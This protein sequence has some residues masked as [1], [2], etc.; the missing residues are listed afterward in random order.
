M[1][2]KEL[3]KNKPDRAI[4]LQGFYL[5]KKLGPSKD[6]REEGAKSKAGGRKR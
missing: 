2:G 3:G 1:S 6:L 5:G 4:I